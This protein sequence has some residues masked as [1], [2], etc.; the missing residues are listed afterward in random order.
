L[1][2][3]PIGGHNQAGNY[4]INVRFNK[5]NLINR[6]ES[7]ADKRNKI[8]LRNIESITFLT[9]IF[10]NANEPYF[11][12]LDPPYYVQGEN[13]YYNFYCDANHVDLA[14]VLKQN[15]NSNWFLTYDNCERIQELYS[16][17]NT[18]YLPMTYTLQ[19]KRKAKEIMVFSDSLYIPKQLRIGSKSEPLSMANS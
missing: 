8:E 16:E 17:F 2:A 6:I 14:D 12:F 18:A 4:K 9:E 11:V 19:D 10:S 15:R 5:E 1:Q 3:G 7:I 13:L